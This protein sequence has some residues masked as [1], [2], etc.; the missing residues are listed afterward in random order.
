MQIN[1]NSKISVFCRNICI[2]FSIVFFFFFF[3]FFAKM[4]DMYEKIYIKLPSS[5]KEC[6]C[7]DILGFLVNSSML[8]LQFW[9]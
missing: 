8:R 7:R 4:R 2:L 3:F 6:Y 1:T 9:W 5:E